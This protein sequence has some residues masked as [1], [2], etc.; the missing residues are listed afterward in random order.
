VGGG[1]GMKEYEK[2]NV[3]AGKYMSVTAYADRISEG[4]MTQI[5]ESTG[6]IISTHYG[7]NVVM[8]DGVFRMNDEY[9]IL[10]PK[11]NG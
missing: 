4:Y 10:M 9:K 11:N 7:D 8:L 6:V 3:P 2:V 1:N 5:P